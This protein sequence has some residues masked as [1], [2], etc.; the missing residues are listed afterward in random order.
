MDI[1]HPHLVNVRDRFLKMYSTLGKSL[2][3]K[4]LPA[5]GTTQKSEIQ[6]GNIHAQFYN[7]VLTSDGKSGIIPVWFIIYQYHEIT[8]EYK[9][10]ATGKTIEQ[11][12]GPKAMQAINPKP[13]HEVSMN[14]TAFYNQH[15][16][17]RYHDLKDKRSNRVGEALLT[18][19]KTL[20]SLSEE[21]V[22][23]VYRIN[24]DTEEPDDRIVMVDLFLKDS[25]D[26]DE[27]GA[28]KSKVKLV[29][30]SPEFINDTLKG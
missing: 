24:P 26:I 5:F 17:S 8:P 23:Q 20:L 2:C 4:Q 22:G 7:F 14:L 18:I 6:E 25:S 12:T 19:R 11:M 28:Y 13:M 15:A 30:A 3:T 16:N 27:N 29:I 9:A 21:C 1:K 10:E